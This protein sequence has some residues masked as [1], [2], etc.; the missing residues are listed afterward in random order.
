MLQ[1]VSAGICLLLASPDSGLQFWVFGQ[2]GIALMIWLLWHPI[3]TLTTVVSCI[4]FALV[5]I[6][7]RNDWM[8]TASI[9][10]TQIGHAA[11]ICMDFVMAAACLACLLSV[12][13]VVQRGI[14]V[15]AAAPLLW[16]M[17]E[18]VFDVGLRLS[19]KTT[20]QSL[21]IGLTQLDGPLAGLARYGGNAFLVAATV[22]SGAVLADVFILPRRSHVLLTVAIFSPGLVTSANYVE[23]VDAIT[24]SIRP[25]TAPNISSLLQA[26]NHDHNTDL[27]VYPENTLTEQT[28]TEIDLQSLASDSNRD[29]RVVPDLLAGVRLLSGSPPALYNTMLQIRNGRVAGTAAKRFLCPGLECESPLLRM[30][31]LAPTTHFVSADEP[32]F[33]TL[34]SGAVAGIGICHDVC[35]TEWSLDLQKRANVFI[36]CSNEGLAD[37]RW[38]NRRATACARLRCLETSRPMIRC[39][40]AGESCVIGATGRILS[41]QPQFQTVSCPLAHE[42][43]Q[44]RYSCLGSHGAIAC[45]ALI[46]IVPQLAVSVFAQQSF[47]LGEEE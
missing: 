44:T 21:S 42:Q 12:R 39:A 19:M 43:T 33:L 34:K 11:W 45:A 20:F 32:Q 3:G 23:P 25:T 36:H 6:V 41:R 35:F 27:I 38:A 28:L 26:N 10:I 13:A 31:S 29:V 8:R 4:L 16:L 1:S 37:S 9:D 14:S 22:L 5:W 24:V 30:L 40:L 15:V 7:P 47:E 2:I 46:L 17:M 18:T